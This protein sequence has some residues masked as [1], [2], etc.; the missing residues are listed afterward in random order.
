MV[1]RD[2]AR[3][4]DWSAGG[5]AE[6]GHLNSINNWRVRFNP[7][8]QSSGRN[9]RSRW[10]RVR[11]KDKSGGSRGFC[12]NKGQFRI[13]GDLFEGTRATNSPKI[14]TLGTLVVVAKIGHRSKL[15]GVHRRL[16]CH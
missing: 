1:Q 15:Q 3:K 11:L 4:F 6:S 8:G 2:F 14:R 10:A 12:I 13:R 7:A 5:L 9:G 16:V